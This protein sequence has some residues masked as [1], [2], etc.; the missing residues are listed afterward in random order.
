MDE[1][2][3]GYEYGWINVYIYIWNW[4]ACRLLLT[5]NNTPPPS[6]STG[7]S[8]LKRSYPSILSSESNIWLDVQLSVIPIISG[9]CTDVVWQWLWQTQYRRHQGNGVVRTEC[10]QYIAARCG[11]RWCRYRWC[12][13]YVDA[14]VMLTKLQNGVDTQVVRFVD[15]K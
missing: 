2:G 14:K 11:Y 7:Q 9:F 12:R 3:Y 15:Q 8:C 10:Q 1:Y 13:C 5:Y 6:R 4:T